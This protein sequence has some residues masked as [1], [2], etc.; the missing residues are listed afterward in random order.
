MMLRKILFVLFSVLV[1]QAQAQE[2]ILNFDV[3]INIERSGT[4]NV[5]ENISIYAEGNDFRHGLLRVLPLTRQDKDGTEID[6]KYTINTI[7][8]DG[9]N[10]KYFTKEE[11]GDWKIYIGDKDVDL[12]SG[13]YDY[14]ISYTVPFQIGYFDQYDELY[15]NV[16]GNGWNLPIDKAT[17]QI[18]LP[19]GNKFENLYCYTGLS[20]SKDSNCVNSLNDKHNIV[21]F[22]AVQL[23]PKEGLTVAASFA[24]GIVDPPTFL[25]ETSSFYKQIKTNLWSV[26]YGI[27]MAIFF[28][29]SWKKY[30]KDPV[31][32]TL[33]PEF[34][35]PFDW[36][37]AITGYVYH[38]K[39]TDK[40]YMSSVV[41]ISVKGAIRILSTLE[42]GV[43]KNKH[44]YE[45]EVLNKQSK[46]LSAEESDI[47]SG[48]VKKEKIEVTDSNYKIFEKAY[49]KWLKTVKKQINLDEFYQ[50]NTQ[51]KWIG[52]AVF[53]IAG[54]S[55]ELLS[56]SKGYISYPF[57]TGLIIAVAGLT[58]WFT[59]KNI[60]TGMLILRAILGF[61]VFAPAV[62]I[63]FISIAFLSSKQI[64]IIGVVFVM[65]IIYVKTLG[66]YTDKGA[67][68][69]YRLEGFKL[70]LKTAEKNRMNM[71]NPPELTPQLFEKLFPY[72]IAL[73]VEIEWGKQF[74]EVLELAKYDPSWYQ[75]DDTFYRQPTLFLSTF[76]NS[77]NTAA[78]NPNPPASSGSSS[79]SSSGSSGS[80]SSGSSGGGS[81]GGGGGGGGGGGW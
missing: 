36:S 11:S 81:S 33:M 4:I 47:V 79:S 25:Q 54:L 10:E 72:A 12:E 51:K 65:Y 5:V 48:F 68:A 16:T 62:A 30:G 20:G 43:F 27:G 42:N 50:N 41:N 60:G 38:K 32:K 34:I 26:I 45:I 77:V 78:V 57:Y 80:W 2:R 37:P 31:K 53:L 9:A 39:V 74:E 19:Y 21:S 14:Q 75:G 61:F 15:W 69:F 46:G 70:Y 6:V 24:K 28:F 56:N 3:K 35:P 17:C 64:I 71:L 66:K 52:F 59:K 23:R 49:S 7:K 29:F 40:T 73:G 67:E 63:F 13:I 1:Y 76:E 55:Y 8:K 44:T 22:T 58:Y 18:S